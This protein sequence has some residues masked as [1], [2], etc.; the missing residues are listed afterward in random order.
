MKTQ[1]EITLLKEIKSKL[2]H[3]D[4]TYDFCKNEG[5]SQKAVDYLSTQK[6]SLKYLKNYFSTCDTSFVQDLIDEGVD[7]ATAFVRESAQN[8]AEDR[9]RKYRWSRNRTQKSWYIDDTNFLINL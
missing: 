3:A 8:L 4:W 6:F 2:D 5:D 7:F 9:C 1:I